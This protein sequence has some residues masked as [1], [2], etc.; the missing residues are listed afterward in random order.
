MFLGPLLIALIPGIVIVLVTWWFKKK[1]FSMFIRLIPGIL[2]VI[3]A[4]VLFYIGFVNIRGFEGAAYG[5]LA[6][7][8]I[9][10]SIV[11]LVIARD[12]KTVTNQYH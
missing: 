10:F 11:S 1:G 8:L 2:A 3:S 4:F 12:K 7:F 9:V 6:L 5:I